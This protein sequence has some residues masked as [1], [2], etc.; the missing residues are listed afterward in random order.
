MYQAGQAIAKFYDAGYAAKKDLVDKAFY[1]ELARGSAEPVLEIACGTGRILLDIAREGLDIHGVDVSADMLSVLREKLSCEPREIQDHVHLYQGDMRSFDLGLRFPLITMP[2]RPMQHMYSVQDQ[3]KALDCAAR[4]LADNG[5]LVFDVFNPNYEI[6]Y[7]GLGVEEQDLQWTD[8]ED[9]SRIVRRY[10]VRREINKLEQW[11]EGEL[12][13][14]VFEGK[15]LVSEERAELKMSYYTYPQLQAL[16][17][18]CQLEIVEEYGDFSKSPIGQ[19]S[20]L[21]FVLKRL[22][23]DR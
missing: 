4:H 13:F 10:F 3:R 22:C 15:C 14:R 16:F 6:L 21:I 23:A 9:P 5:R 17:E 8:P 12:I 2:F 11:F 20:E 19:G 7:S 18:L 1:L